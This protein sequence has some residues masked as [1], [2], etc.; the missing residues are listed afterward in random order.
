MGAEIASVIVGTVSTGVVGLAGIIATYRTSKK[1]A[2]A[3]EHLQTRREKREDEQR[4]HADRIAAAAELTKAAYLIGE[5][6][7]L[8]AKARI[9]G[10]TQP[11]IEPREVTERLDRYNAAWMTAGFFFPSLRGQMDVF[12]PAEFDQATTHAERAAVRA[13]F[14]LRWNRMQSELTRRLGLEDP[15]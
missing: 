7:A 1:T 4:H 6:Y 2:Q 14:G 13:S 15:S 11:L 3:V 10:L 12:V 8:K 5:A 9:D